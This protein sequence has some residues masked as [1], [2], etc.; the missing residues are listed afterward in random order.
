MKNSPV[1]TVNAVSAYCTYG[2]NNGEITAYP[3]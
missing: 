1:L 3:K 2:Q